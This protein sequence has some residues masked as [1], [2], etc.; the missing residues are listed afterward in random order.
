MFDRLALVQEDLRTR[1]AEPH[2]AYH[3]QAHIDAM[4]ERFRAARETFHAPEAVELA[5]W[6][7]DAVYDPVQQITNEGALPCCAARWV[8]WSPRRCWKRPN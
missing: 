7:H 5:I 2:R 8:G 1:L 6:F 4:L 3:G